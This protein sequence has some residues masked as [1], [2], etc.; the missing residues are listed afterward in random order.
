MAKISLHTLEVGIDPGSLYTRLQVDAQQLSEPSLAAAD[1]ITG[2][3]VAVGTEAS[4]LLKGAAERLRAVRP[5]VDGRVAEPEAARLLM[6]RLLGKVQ[7][8][9]VTRPAVC[10]AVPRELSAVEKRAWLDTTR[11]AGAS[12]TILLDRGAAAVIGAGLEPFR[13]QAMLGVDL[14]VGMTAALLSCGGYV[15]TLYA[16]DGGRAVTRSLQA[17]LREQTWLD[18]APAVLNALQRDVLSTFGGEDRSLPVTGRNLA[19]GTLAELQI[20][21]AQLQPLAQAQAE[22]IA[23]R[24]VR[25]L[26]KAPAE[27]P[28]DLWR[29]GIILSGG[30]SLL[31]G[32]AES[33]QE[34]LGIRVK[35]VQEPFGTVALGAARALQKKREY[36]YLFEGTDEEQGRSAR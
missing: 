9:R 36:R 31:H 23:R 5:F 22:R 3:I 2:N 20:R 29:E 19:D 14:G 6:E 4:I 12:S 26:R 24:L 17:Y 33:L 1:F 35:R 30:G 7:R 18:V 25:L 15:R 27:I 32:L 10:L 21:A 28:A 8:G 16:A 34:L 13:P 11:H